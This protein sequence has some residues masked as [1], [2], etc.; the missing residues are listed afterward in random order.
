MRVP[1]PL[2][3]WLEPW[4]RS[5][6]VLGR[7]VLLLGVVDIASAVTRAERSRLET[8]REVVP[9][10]VVTA[11]GAITLATGLVLVLLSRGLR[12]RKRSAW[13][14]TVAL[15][16]LSIVTHLLKGLDAEEATVSLLLLVALLLQHQAFTAEGDPRTRLRALAALIGLGVA[17]VL[18]GTAAIALR[19]DGLAQPFSLFT[20]AGAAARS[21][22][23][24]PTPALWQD[25]RMGRHDARQTGEM[26]LVLGLLT[27][28]TT[29]YLALRPAD[30]EGALTEQDRDRMRALL[31]THGH[32]DSLGYFALR[33]DKS[34]V[35]SPTEKAC[36]TFRVVGGVMLAS[37]DP[38]GD[39]ESWP[40]AQ[41]AFLAIAQ[42]HAWIPAVMGCGE[43]A[44]RSWSRQGLSA[45]EIG[46]EAI[47]DVDTFRL[48]GRAMR[49]VRQAVARVQRAGYTCRMT[50]VGDLSADERDR[51]REQ[52]TAWRGAKVERGFSMALGRFGHEDDGDC[53]LVTAHL[54]GELRALLHFVP[55]GPDGWS[56]DLMR[57]DRTADNGLNELMITYALQQ[58]AGLGVRRV[59]LNFAM[60]RDALERGEQL[61]AGPLIRAWRWLLVF[62]SRWWQIESLYRFNAKFQPQWAPRFVCYPCAADLPRVALATLEAEAFLV[63]PQLRRRRAVVASLPLLAAPDPRT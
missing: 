7:L 48:D 63:R 9:N 44:G 41:Q 62:G 4:K 3:R 18:L 36:I 26:S 15:V 43:L 40:K 49:N 35:W 58:A 5:P 60:F 25:N 33:G 54:D 8:L 29:L 23:G 16:S 6:S 13:L 27:G 11:S 12:R 50:R 31:A 56:L 32:R 20:S 21:M 45:L 55:W 28:L 52:A 24:L 61:G 10:G 47:I 37:G 14:M 22:V 30:G 2:Q 1:A 34:V 38:L 39:P 57:R 17:G 46:D 42:R 53:V 19:D 59:S 51:V